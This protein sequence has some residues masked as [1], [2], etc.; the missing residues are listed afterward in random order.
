[1][2]KI[3]NVL[4]IDDNETDLFI[5]EKLME[6]YGFSNKICK[7]R[8]CAEALDYLT[9]ECSNKENLPDYIFVDLFMPA[10]DGYFFLDA[11]SKMSKLIKKKCKVIILSIL[12]NEEEAQKLLKNKDV[13]TLLQK[14][15]TKESLD[16]LKEL[17]YISNKFTLK[18]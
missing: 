2:Q 4:L 11:Y 14:P 5:S 3:R 9:N 17:H 10:E 16:A 1:M 15:L 7:K 6:Q 8:S 18:H 13:Y 12:I